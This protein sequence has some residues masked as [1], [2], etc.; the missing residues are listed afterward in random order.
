[1]VMMILA[2]EICIEVKSIGNTWG[3]MEFN[4]KLYFEA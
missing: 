2:P 4:K 1:M 3:E